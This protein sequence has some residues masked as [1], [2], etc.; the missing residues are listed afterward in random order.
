MF[1]IPA[2]KELLGRFQQVNPGLPGLTGEAEGRFDWGR[3]VGDL[4]GGEDGEQREIV[5]FG[6]DLVGEGGGEVAGF[7]Q[8][9][10]EKRF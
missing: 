4:T 6:W 2:T 5:R 9:K 10:G 7:G 3:G 1:G 8:R